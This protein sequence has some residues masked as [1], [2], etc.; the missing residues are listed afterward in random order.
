MPEYHTSKEQSTGRE[1]LLQNMKETLKD[2]FLSFCTAAGLAAFYILMEEDVTEAVGPKGKHNSNRKAYRHGTEATSIIMAGQNIPINRPRVRTV[3]GREVEIGVYKLAKD[4]DLLCQ[5][6]LG[7][8]LHGMSSR[9]FNYGSE[10]PN[11]KG[12]TKSTVSRRFIQ[13]TEKELRKFMSRRIPGIVVLFV[14]GVQFASHNV[15]VAMGVDAGGKKHM[16]GFKI[17]A[18]ENARVCQDLLVDLCERGLNVDDGILSVIDGSKALRKA[19]TAVFGDKVL[20]QR[21]QVHK[22][23]NIRGYLPN[24]AWPWVT[25]VINR[26]WA[27]DNADEAIRSLKVLATRLEEA[28]PDAAASL[29]EGIEET[30]TVQG[31]AI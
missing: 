28:Y 13:A 3:D 31:L 27:Q 9:N 16:L 6:A 7:R 17:G 15:I 25:Q 5:V 30:V 18:T 24:S 19:I 14:D 12:P 1:D 29:R 2:G 21:C 20:I 10:I 26:A 8:M 4:E 11:S 23:R 22:K